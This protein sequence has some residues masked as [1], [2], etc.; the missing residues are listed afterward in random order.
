M[1]RVG[2][3]RG[4][5]SEE[6]LAARREQRNL[7]L[8]QRLQG[9]RGCGEGWKA[10]RIVPMRTRGNEPSCPRRSRTG[11]DAAFDALDLCLYFLPP[12]PSC[13]DV[14][15]AFRVGLGLGC[16]LFGGLL[17]LLQLQQSLLLPCFFL[18]LLCLGCRVS[19]VQ[20]SRETLK[21]GRGGSL[22]FALSGCGER[23]SGRASFG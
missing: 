6:G 16:F 5:R 12:L 15:G 18:C 13:F 4:E 20:T 19:R 17:A 21:G 22:T 10:G 8:R 3:L 7:V 1:Q 11:F 2:K 23:R 14:V 9:Y